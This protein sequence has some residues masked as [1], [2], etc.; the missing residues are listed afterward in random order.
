MRG[1]VWTVTA[2][3]YAWKPQPTVV[4]QSD[5]LENVGSVIVCM[6]TTHD[7]V[8]GETRVQVEPNSENGL[9]QLLCHGRKASLCEA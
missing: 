6:S 2:S 4:V 1:E 9:V 8:D 5:I 7:T 3:G